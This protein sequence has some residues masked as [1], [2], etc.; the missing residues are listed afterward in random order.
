M[1]LKWLDAREAAEVGTALA[2]DFVLQSGPGSKGARR[3]DGT[4]GAPAE[5]QRFLQKF[6]QR[7]DREARPLKL[8]LFKRA[9]LANSFKWRLLEKG[10]EPPLV[11][12]LTQALVL[13]LTGNRGTAAQEQPAAVP[14]GAPRKLRAT[15]AQALHVQGNAHLEQGAYNEAL[16]CYQELLQAD[17]RDAHAHNGMGI[18]LARLAR[19]PEAEDHLRRALGIRENFPEAHFN[20]AGV[21][22]STGRYVEAEQPLRRTLKL[23]PDHLDARIALAGCLLLISR[24]SE[25]RDAYEKVLRAAP[26][27][28]TALV[29]LGQVDAMEGRFAEAEAAYRRALEVEPGASYAWAAIAGL[30]KMTAADRDWV[31][32]AEEIADSGLH[33]RDEV[34]LR[35]A[36][37][38]YYDDVGDF[39]R[40]FRSYQRANELHKLAA[41]PYR[42]EVHA[43][44]VDDLI[45]VYSQEAVARAS[46]GGSGSERPVFV[47][48]MPRS[49]T[50]L[51]EQI[52]AAHPAAYGA[53]ELNFW[54]AFFHKREASAVSQM[55]PEE[56]TRRKLAQDY[57]RVL[58]GY[59]ADAAR[60]VDKAPI[61]SD[62]LGLIHAVFPK[63]RVL[64][65]QR[66]PIDVCLSC[67]FQQFSPVM[68]YT[69]DLGDLANFYRE[70]RRL[71]AHW[72]AVLPRDTLLEVPYAE[73]VAKQETWTRRILEFLG[74]PW[75][76]SC[77]EFHKLN[78]AVTTASTWQVRQK[79]YKSSVAR[80]RNYEKF[81]QPL[82]SLRDLDS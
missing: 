73:L 7:V 59:S 39:D 67:Y 37:G 43:R 3:K 57:L 28:P 23:Q 21:L 1:M 66:D 82:L 51:V 2:D 80:W 12:E 46:A 6:L 60:V 13:R 29:G 11:D 63:A 75:D 10:V 69:M 50:S 15:G 77:L 25:S 71:M 35:F 68:S 74:L 54:T 14:S 56:S 49:G 9:K 17:P 4:A 47:V 72:R 65:L 42:P 19:Y 30:R 62:Y 5:L 55:L 20:L 27:N 8:N 76:D 22:L 33:S 36:I 32:R 16:Q 26:R 44:F 53:G 24:V 64:Y 18:A 38:K 52:I 81:I 41:R 78:R 40:A 45:R 48:G 58:S 34:V 31:K 61:N 79:I 70:H